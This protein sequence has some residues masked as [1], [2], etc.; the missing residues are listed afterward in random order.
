MNRKLILAI[1]IAAIS[2][3]VAYLLRMGSVTQSGQP[4][5]DL[6]KK[7]SDPSTLSMDQTERERAAIETS[8]AQAGFQQMQFTALATVLSVQELVEA[9]TSVATAQAQSDRASAQRH[10]SRRELDRLQALHAQD[11]NVSDK[12]VEAAEAMW[13]S[14]EAAVLAT[15]AATDAAVS[16]ARTRWGSQLTQ[17]LVNRT[18]LYRHL[19]SQHKVLLRVVATSDATQAQMPKT[20]DVEDPS[21]V[22][23]HAQLISRTPSVDPRIQGTAYFYVMEP[24]DTAAGMVLNARFHTELPQAGAVVPTDA[25]IWWQGKQCLYVETEPGRFER[26]V[27]VSARRTGDGWFIPGFPAVTVVSRGAQALLSQQ[28]RSSIKVGEEGP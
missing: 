8:Q 20:I 15:R 22:S 13:R 1:V 28:M 26:R 7:T 17:A 19:E 27:V 5:T 21:G 12:S 11:R 10:A 24:Q 16:S 18:T 25:L 2:V 14:D 6:I 23:R 9:A 3:V 4:M